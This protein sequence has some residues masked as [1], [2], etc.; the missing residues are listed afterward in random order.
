MLRSGA[1]QLLVLLLLVFGGETRKAKPNIVIVVA[2]D[3]GYTDAGF[4]GGDQIPTPHID[5]LAHEGIILDNYYTAM[6]CTPSRAALLTGRHPMQLGLQKAV[7]APTEPFGLG[8]NET[9][10]PQYLKKYG[11][12]TH[13]I[14]KWHLG[15]Y[16]LAFTPTQRGFDTHLGFWADKTDYFSHEN[17]GHR[18][19]SKIIGLDF[20]E[21]LKVAR[22][23][24]GSYG[25]ELF[26]NRAVDLILSHD[27]SK[28]F[29]LYLPHQAVH[30]GITPQPLKA[31]QEYLDRFKFI[32]HD[33]RRR[34]AAMLSVLDDSIGNLTAALKKSG[35]YE[36]TILIF[37]TDNGGPADGVSHN[38]ASNWP[39]RGCKHTNWE[40]GVRAVSFIHS[41]LLKNPGT[42]SHHLMHISDWLP[43]IMTAIG[44]KLPKDIDYYGV[45]QWPSIQFNSPSARNELMHNYD[46]GA[47]AIRYGDYKLVIC[48]T[49]NKNGWYPEEH[50]YIGA[51][52]KP[53]IFCG[54][55]NS[56]LPSCT[57]ANKY[58]LFDIASDPCEY[59]NIA[60]LKPDLAEK[61]YNKLMT[62]ADAAQPPR[63][64]PS[65]PASYPD[66]HNGH[67]TDWLDKHPIF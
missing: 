21:N 64:K 66:L 67:W 22:E 57:S 23:Y 43:T 24:N 56:S 61:L 65:D 49:I 1:C 29:F 26:G 13:M 62:F 3:M 41:P 54:E 40:G 44:E 7:V 15:S 28:P 16:K 51:N 46:D 2:D 55:R 47:G 14:G 25:T 34:Y 6:I 48:C 9:L 60:S 30:A 59:N 35:M 20:W 32:Q 39:L 31:P 37:T 33:G 63:N 8:L 53:Y 12:V 17:K 18:N 19:A 4:H 52:Q 36:N 10:L 27:Q 58:C 45:D 50:F 42:T 11:Y 5:K 38:Y